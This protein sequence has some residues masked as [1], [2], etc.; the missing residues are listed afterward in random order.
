[1]DNDLNDFSGH[2]GWNSQNPG[3]C[4]TFKSDT[5]PDGRKVNPRQTDLSDLEYGLRLELVCHYLLRAYLCLK[6]KRL[7]LIP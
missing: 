6:N 5:V 7:A 4:Y 1:M 3:N 2:I